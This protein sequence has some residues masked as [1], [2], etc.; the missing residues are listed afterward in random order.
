MTTILRAASAAI[1]S[2]ALLIALAACA[3]AAPQTTPAPTATTSAVSD[4]ACTDGTGITVAV[5]ASA[6]A[7]GESK[8]WCINTTETLTAAAAL[9]L[10]N[11]STVGTKQYGDQVVCRVNGVPASD[12]K[13]PNPDGSDYFET[14]EGM[15]AAFAYWALWVKPAGG[16]WGFAQEGAATQK[17][18]PGEGVEL[19]F[20]LNGK[21]AAPAN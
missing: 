13:I 7:N 14:C 6:L 3:S 4:H 15:P 2:S 5:D 21:P 12:T 16:A 18:A 20:Q 10:V 19:L 17:V 11:V 9:K 8:A 1:A